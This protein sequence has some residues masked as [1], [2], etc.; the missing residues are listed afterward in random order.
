[1]ARRK[2]NYLYRT[3]GSAAIDPYYEEY[4]RESVARPLPQELPQPRPQRAPKPGKSP[5]P[6]RTPVERQRMEIAPTAVLGLVLSGMMLVLVIFGYAQVYA[7]ACQVGE[8]EAQVQQLQE[9]NARLQNQYDT[10]VDLSEVESRARELGMHQPTA[11][12][13]ILLRVPAE[14]VTVVAEKTSGNIFLA[15]WDAITRT[16][17]DLWAYLR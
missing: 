15:V 11:R 9:H 6:R 4:G 13:T 16:A 14:D 2:R 7:S 17:R 10:S 1:M 8:L 5:R 12:Q 3:V